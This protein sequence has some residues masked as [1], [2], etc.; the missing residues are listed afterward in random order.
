M[1]VASSPAPAVPRRVVVA[2]TVA[3]AIVF[4]C[5][6][7]PYCLFNADPARYVA[8]ARALADGDGYR[9]FGSRIYAFR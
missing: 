6:T 3:L 4:A 7:G 2:I 1:T 9:Y 8:L 5:L